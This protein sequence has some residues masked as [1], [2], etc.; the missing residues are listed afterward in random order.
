MGHVARDASL[1]R[2]FQEKQIDLRA[3]RSIE[4]HFWS[5]SE[6]ES[7]ALAE[8]LKQRGFEILRRTRAA[9]ANDPARWN[10][11]ASVK[12][13]IELTM[14]R[15]FIGDLV[16]LADSYGGLYDGWGTSI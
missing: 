10:L 11:E 4:C 9:I 12:Q 16:K 8:A 7:A 6:E 15:E 3:P 13:S 5:W 1:L 14:T 2:L